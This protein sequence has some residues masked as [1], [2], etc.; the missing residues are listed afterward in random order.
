[1]K[2]IRYTNIGYSSKVILD[3]LVFDIAEWQEKLKSRSNAI[4]NLQS[5]QTR[6]KYTGELGRINECLIVLKSIVEYIQFRKN[7]GKK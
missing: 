7:K 2:T 4:D 1:M 5:E 3:D 6:Q